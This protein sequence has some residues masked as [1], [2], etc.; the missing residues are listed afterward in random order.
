MVID[1]RSALSMANTATPRHQTVNNAVY[2][3]QTYAILW[4][5]TLTVMLV[6]DAAMLALA[7]C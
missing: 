5:V 3:L 1:S 6:D 4:S 2:T 7:F